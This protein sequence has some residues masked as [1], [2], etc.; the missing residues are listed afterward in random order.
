MGKKLAIKSQLHSNDST[1]TKKKKKKGKELKLWMQRNNVWEN[2][3]YQQL[4]R[5]GVK[6]PDSIKNL[7][8]NQF[9]CIV[10]KVRVDRF[11]QVKDQAARN[12][13]DKLLVQFEKIWRKKSG[14][15]K[16]NLRNYA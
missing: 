6:D 13:C 7:S 16:T 9:D 5:K 10:R 2:T 14:I 12:R 3:L 15:K 8:E 1:K 4:L 11:A